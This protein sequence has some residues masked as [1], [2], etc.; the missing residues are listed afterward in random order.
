MS[1]EVETPYTVR[2]V[3]AL[4]GLSPRIIA[5]LFEREPG[6]IVYEVH[7]PRRKRKH[8]PLSASPPRF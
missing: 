6:V 2:E 5:Q 4:T 8:Y 7:N 1:T 3:S